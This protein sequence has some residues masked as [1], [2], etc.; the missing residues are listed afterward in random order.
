MLEVRVHIGGG[1]EALITVDSTLYPEEQKPEPLNEIISELKAIKEQ[2]SLMAK[3]CKCCGTARREGNYKIKI[4]KAREIPKGQ[5]FV[6]D[7]DGV[8]DPPIE[9]SIHRRDCEGS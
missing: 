6:Y 5:G 3:H 7:P 1:N 9:S 2:Q 8:Y 4:L